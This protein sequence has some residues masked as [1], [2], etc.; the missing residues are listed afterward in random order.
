MALSLASHGP[1]LPRGKPTAVSFQRK[2]SF[3]M[4]I[5]CEV[6]IKSYDPFT[7]LIAICYHRAIY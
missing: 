6:M 4:P 5:F 2:Y 3:Q 7:N 1:E